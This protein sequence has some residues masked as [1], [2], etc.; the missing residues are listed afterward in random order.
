M[1]ETEAQSG[2]GAAEGPWW[3]L[4]GSGSARCVAQLRHGETRAVPSISQPVTHPKPTLGRTQPPMWVP[5]FVPKSLLGVQPRSCTGRIRPLSGTDP[6]C[7]L[8]VSLITANADL[9]PF[10]PSYLI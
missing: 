8:G 1:G 2:A 5:L 10:F 7:I 4:R 6:T 3:V 9:W